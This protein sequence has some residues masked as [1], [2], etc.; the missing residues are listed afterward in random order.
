MPKATHERGDYY[1]KQI[2]YGEDE[3]EVMKFHEKYSNADVKPSGVAASSIGE[4]Q[5]TINDNIM[6]LGKDMVER[7]HRQDEEL[8]NLRAQVAG[9]QELAELK[10]LVKNL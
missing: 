7:S 10:E 9:S 1:P 2:Y 6:A 8:S 4:T 5:R 3:E